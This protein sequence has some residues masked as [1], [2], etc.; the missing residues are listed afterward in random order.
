MDRDVTMYVLVS[1]IICK[2]F[3]CA[4]NM[5]VVHRYDHSGRMTNAEDDSRKLL[6]WLRVRKKV[7]END[8][9]MPVDIVKSFFAMQQGQMLRKI[10]RRM[11]TEMRESYR[12][13][14]VAKNSKQPND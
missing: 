13:R 9:S 6:A 14:S 1:L 7:R 8:G 4:S 11:L 5:T 3:S 2:C 12:N 10:C